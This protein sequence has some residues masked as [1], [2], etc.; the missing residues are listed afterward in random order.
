[1]EKE[2][3]LIRNS[4]FIVSSIREYINNGMFFDI[5]EIA[6]MKDIFKSNKLSAENFVALL[7]DGMKRVSTSKLY[8]YFRNITSSITNIQDA[9]IILKAMKK[10]LKLKV[11]NDIIKLIEQNYNTNNDF[12]K[13]IN[14]LEE[15]VQKLREENEDLKR[16][17]HSNDFLKSY[18]SQY[19]KSK[20]FDLIYKF[21]ENLS[22]KGNQI[23]MKKSCKEKIS[24]KKNNNGDTVVRV[25]IEKG[26]LNLVKSLIECGCNKSSKNKYGSDLLIIASYNGK[27]DIVKYLISIGFDK[28]TKNKLGYTPLTCAANQGHLDVIK[29][30]V[31]IGADYNVKDHKD[32]LTPLMWAAFSGHLENVK[33]LASLGADIEA[34]D[35][36]GNSPLTWATIRRHF[37]LVKYL[38]LEAHVETNQPNL[39]RKTPLDY[40]LKYETNDDCSKEIVRILVESRF[41]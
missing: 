33:Y 19:K 4:E 21:F 30:L 38:V 26:N 18:L 2:I 35:S 23:V 40:A 29:Y 28:E 31:S 41:K 3:E 1:M 22:E 39:R 15:S 34:K 25:A 14:N 17:S 32:K 37:E 36:K 6:D 7:K 27:L 5:F 12:E 20:D 24:E 11:L 13:R 8:R 10:C 9:I 16:I